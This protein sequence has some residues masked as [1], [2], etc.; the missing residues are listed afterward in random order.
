MTSGVTYLNVSVLF[1]R[2]LSSASPCELYLNT[3]PPI[4]LTEERCVE[5]SSNV[6]Y[7]IVCPICHDQYEVYY[8]IPNNTFFSIADCSDSGIY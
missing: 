8:E 4:S 6:N 1:N 7:S 2:S 3:G 5:V